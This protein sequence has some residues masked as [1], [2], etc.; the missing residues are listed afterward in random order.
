MKITRA[1][2]EADNK[3]LWQELNKTRDKNK[4]LL[5]MLEQVDNERLML[6]AS[7]KQSS[8]IST[9]LVSKLAKESNYI[10]DVKEMGEYNKSVTTR[11]EMTEEGNIS[12]QL[13]E[14]G[15]ET[16]DNTNHDSPKDQEKQST[17]L[18]QE[19]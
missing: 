2:L 7:M 8:E 19:S 10:L 4:K 5:E 18:P 12:I 6:K 9:Y 1:M 3:R 16:V 14:K 17:D 13:I 15:G 11:S